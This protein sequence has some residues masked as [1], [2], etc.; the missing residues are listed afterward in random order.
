VERLRERH[1]V[2]VLTGDHEHERAASREGVW[3][4]L[5]WLA[6]DWHG[7]VRAPVAARRAVKL[8][9]RALRW[10]PDLVYAWNNSGV[11]QATLRVLADNGVPVAFRVCS[12]GIGEIFVADQFMRELLPA[13]RRPARAVWSAGCRSLNSLPSMRLRPTAPMRAAISWNSEFIRSAVSLPPFVEPVLERVGHSV[14][15]HGDLYAGVARDPAPE[16]EIVF[17]GRVTPFKG[18]SVAIEALALLRSEYGITARLVVIGHEDADHGTEM[19]GLAERLGVAESIDWRGQLT[20][21]QAAGVLARTHAMIVPSLWLEPFPLV[22]IEGALAHVP[23]VAA[24]IGGIGEGMLDE[25]HALLYNPGDA[26]AAATALMRTLREGEETQARVE[27]AHERAQEFRLGP[28]L[29]D[30]E[31]FVLDAA[32]ALGSTMGRTGRPVQAS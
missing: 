23:L 2:L 21:E 18:L 3:R 8:A 17:L 9:T 32:A 28:Y 27:R 14:P 5:P 4:E 15:R 29:D 1:D 31:Q 20:P 25:E 22:T 11:S 12:H 13:R 24:D 19:R 26:A 7:A 16:P 10:Q 6:D 30:Q